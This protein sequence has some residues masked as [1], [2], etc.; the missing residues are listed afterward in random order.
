M[1]SLPIWMITVLTEFAPAIYEMSTWYKVEMLVAGVILAT[2]KRTV[3]AVLRVMGLAQD[4]NY[5]KYHHVLSRAIWSGLEVSGILLRLLLK[6]FDT[7]GPLVFGIDETIERRRGDKIAAKGIYRDGVR[8]SK[9]HFVKASGLR[10]ISVMW[11]TRIP[12]AELIWALPFLTALAPSERYYEQRGKQAKTLTDWARQLVV[13]VRRFLPERALI[14]VADSSYAALDFLHACQALSRPVTV[15]TRL[16]LDAALYEPAPPYC[17]K[18]RPRKKGKRLATPQQLIDAPTTC[19]M[20][21]PFVWYNHQVR[22]IEISTHQAVW[23]H[24]GQAPLPIRFIL[25]RDVQGKFDPQVLL[26]TDLSLDPLDIL[27]FFKRRWQ[28]EPTFRHVRE[29]LGVETQRQWSDQAIARTTPV[30]L[31]LFSLITVL[32]QSL[33]TRSALPLRSAAW[34]AKPRPTFSDAL[35]L[36]RS[37]L[38]AHLTFQMSASDPDIVKVPR[39]LLERFN[40]LLTYAT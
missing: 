24:N 35:A 2:G 26:C 13:Q 31:G 9:S 6:T 32:A 38:W 19:W 12:F 29:H 33:S 14:F 5:A 11:L 18:G 3:S 4:R 16:R 34:Y 23:F 30:L 37:R 36:V 8:S 40:D 15:I 7:G 28:M 39:L 25:I 22:D 20:R 10:W 1:L 27:V 17:G 21:L